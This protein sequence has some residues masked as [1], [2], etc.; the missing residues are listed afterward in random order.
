[1]LSQFDDGAYLDP[2][3]AEVMTRVEAAPHPNAAASASH[4]GAEVTVTT[5]DGR[6]LTKALDIALGRTSANPLPR[7]VLETKYRDC[8]GRVLDADAVARSLELLAKFETL[9][10]V[11]ALG[12]VLAAGCA[13]ER[14]PAPALARAV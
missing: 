1:V 7:A 11:A 9:D 12:D 6:R 13:P 14:A 2:R 10:R 5:T 8:A 4:F 3:V